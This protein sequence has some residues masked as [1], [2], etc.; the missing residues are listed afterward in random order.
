MNQDLDELKV[1]V[2]ALEQNLANLSEM[3]VKL[4][5]VL[6]DIAQCILPEEVEQSNETDR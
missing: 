3:V 2:E 5:S 4:E 1:R 6:D